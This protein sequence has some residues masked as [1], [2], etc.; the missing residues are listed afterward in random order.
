MRSSTT[1]VSYPLWRPARPG[2]DRVLDIALKVLIPLGVAAALI[3]GAKLGSFDSYIHLFDSQRF[4][5]PLLA[6]GSSYGL[7]FLVMQCI[8][9]V[10]WLRYR[11]Y[12]LPDQPLPKVSVIIPAYNE[13]AMVEKAIYSVAA[14]DYPADRLEIF[15]IDDGSK[16]DTWEYI[17]RAAKRLPGLIKAIRFPVNRGKREALYAGFKQ[18]KGEFFVTVDSDS[19]IQPDT[20]KHILAPM[21]HNPG[22]GAVAGNVKIYNRHANLL[23]RMLFVRFVLSFD[24]LRASQ[25]MYGFVF[26]TPGALSAYRREAV[27]PVLDEWRGQT[28][29]GRRCNIGEDRAFTNLV[30]R[31]GYHTFYQRSAVVFTTVPETYRGLCK[32]FLRWDRSNFRE[33]YIQLKFMFTRY[34]EKHRLMP[35][36]DFFVRELEFPLTMIFVPL[37]L[38]AIFL[39][40]LILAKVI[41]AMAVVS[42]VLYAYYLATERDL[43]FVYGVLFTFYTFFLLKWIKPYAFLTLRDGRW[44]T[45]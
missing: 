24:F 10:Y 2:W 27:W 41:A 1:T 20:L 11:A 37:L 33:S 29:L 43:D 7:A 25:A 30:L 42:F 45:R 26:C 8:R 36:L 22:I 28:F 35:I 17:D 14:S 3:I 13:G 21:M 38:V 40:P 19:V 31:Q 5:T 32:M 18:A 12:P 4:S 6:I 23:T 34:R 15:C 44:L 39:N 16:D 9:T